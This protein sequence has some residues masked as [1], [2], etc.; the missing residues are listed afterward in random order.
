M[1]AEGPTNTRLPFLGFGFANIMQQSRPPEPKDMVEHFL[2]AHIRVRR[3][4]SA[5]GRF[6]GYGIEHLQRV[7]EIVFVSA[8]IYRFYPFQGRHFREDDIQ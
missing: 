3:R 4:I 7:V 6:F 2:L 1:I 8:S 5:Q